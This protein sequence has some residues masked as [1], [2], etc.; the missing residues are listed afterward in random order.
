ML[1]KQ[2]PGMSI[3]WIWFGSTTSLSAE[4]RRK[5]ERAESL[6]AE[7]E[8][9]LAEMARI[10]KKLDAGTAKRMKALHPAKLARSR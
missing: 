4:Y 5:I 3:E 7:Q 9:T 6:D 10:K 1:H 2:F 8:E